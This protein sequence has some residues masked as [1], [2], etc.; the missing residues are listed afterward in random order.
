MLNVVLRPV[1]MVVGLLAGI[2][3]TYVIISFSADG[4]HNIITQISAILVA[5]QFMS[6]VPLVCCVYCFMQA[7]FPL[8]LI[9]V[10][11]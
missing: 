7:L 11:H 8:L 4:F 1:L 2:V 3:L 9:N 6:T 5:V 10:S